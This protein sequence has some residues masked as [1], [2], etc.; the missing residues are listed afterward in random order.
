V[1]SKKAKEINIETGN[2]SLQYTP[3]LAGLME[4]I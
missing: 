1:Y 4:S 3:L 2:T